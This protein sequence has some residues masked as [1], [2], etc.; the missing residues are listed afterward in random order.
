MGHVVA[1]P[2]PPQCSW[3]PVSVGR[4][5]YKQDSA[6]VPWYGHEAHCESGKAS[7]LSVDVFPS[8]YSVI[9]MISVLFPALFFTGWASTA[10]LLNYIILLHRLIWFSDWRIGTTYCLSH[11]PTPNILRTVVTENQ[12]PSCF[13]AVCLLS[14]PF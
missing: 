12:H 5:T 2:G 1:T 6:Q 3:T 4:F 9:M 13:K 8:K 10:T 7:L 11:E 14:L